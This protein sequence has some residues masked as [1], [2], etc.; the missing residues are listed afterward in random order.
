MGRLTPSREQKWRNPRETTTPEVLNSLRN[1]TRSLFPGEN[2]LSSST[3]VLGACHLLW[4]SRSQG[5]M[6]SRTMV[7]LV[8]DSGGTTLRNSNSRTLL[9]TLFFRLACSLAPA[10]KEEVPPRPHLYSALSPRDAWHVTPSH[11]LPRSDVDPREPS[12]SHL[13][14]APEPRANPRGKD[15]PLAWYRKKD[16]LLS[17][18]IDFYAIN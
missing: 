13:M 10:K 16:N 6:C 7:I 11:W 8:G 3:Y 9:Q 4:P 2:C 18:Y 17:R 15:N 12:Q 14:Q 1:Y 5:A